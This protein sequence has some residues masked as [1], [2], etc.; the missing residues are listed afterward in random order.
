[1]MNDKEPVDGELGDRRRGQNPDMLQMPAILSILLLISHN[2]RTIC[3]HC[4]LLQIHTCLSELDMFQFRKHLDA[5]V[6]LKSWK[7]VKEK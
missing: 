6:N 3:T 5:D 7:S 1:M 4:S 2:S